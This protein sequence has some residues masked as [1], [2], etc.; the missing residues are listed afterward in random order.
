MSNPHFRAAIVT[1]AFL[2]GFA[3]ASLSLT[4]VAAEPPSE[5][6]EPTGH[7]VVRLSREPGS[8]SLYF[9]Q[10]AYTASGDKMIISTREGLSTIN[11]KTREIEPVV[12]GRAGQV[13][14]GRKSRQVYY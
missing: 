8:A 14:V 5:W 1:P 4:A 6:I 11:L 12:E 3:L 2:A 10:N 9:H 13:V 7:R